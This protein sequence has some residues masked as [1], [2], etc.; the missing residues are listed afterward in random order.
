MQKK[1]FL[2][3]HPGAL[4]D[5]IL[6]WPVLISMRQLMPEYE[7]T[8]IG[9]LPYLQIAQR[10][11]LLDNLHDVNARY[12]TNFFSGE[13]FP[14]QLG[15]PAGAILWL[16]HSD[17]MRNVLQS[18]VQQPIIT[19]SPRPAIQHHIS[20]Y[21]LQQ[22]QRYY[23]ITFSNSIVSKIEFR[24]RKKNGNLIVIHPGSGSSKKNFS[25]TFYKTVFELFKERGF[26]NVSIL[27]G[28]AEI[29]QH[30]NEELKSTSLLF[31]ENLDQLLKIFQT[32]A[33]YVGNDSGV[34]HLAGI[35]GIPSIVLYKSTN[36]AVWGVM[37]K[38]VHLI[39][40]KQEEVVFNQIKNVIE[41]TKI[42]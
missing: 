39:S 12:L 35:F 5:F 40:G 17:E 34:S 1:S 18:V 8:A 9:Q 20:I 27:L 16:T 36:P 11:N 31:S 22:V 29:E 7:F 37:G 26:S 30:L 28:P 2:F 21:Y 23:P 4:G 42:P 32:T 41:S 25:T 38:R 15:K 13:K 3:C 10:L 6:I 19:L 33:L 14:S 24:L